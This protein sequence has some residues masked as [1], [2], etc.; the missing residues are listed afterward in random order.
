[1]SDTPFGFSNPDDDP[2]RKKDEGSGSGGG[3]PFGF[4][5]PGGGGDNPFG[6]QGFDPAQFGQM[7]SQFGQMLAGMGSAMG[8]GGAGPVNYEIAS[9][10]AR[11]Q[12]GSVTPVSAG[13]ADAVRDASRLAELWLDAATTLPAG[14]TKTVA[15]TPVEWLENTLDTWKRLCDPIAEQVNG[16]MLQGLP[17]EARAM[18]GPMMGMFSQMGGVAFGSQL[19]QALGQLS[20]EVMTSTDIGLPLGPAGT[21]ALLPAAIEE[22]GEGLEQP[23]QEI[24][25]FIAAR[26]AA[27]QRLYSH[28]PWLRQRLLA[29]VEEYARGIRMDMSSIEDLA[30]GLDPSALSD[31][32]KIEEIL[33]QG[34]FEPQT[35]PEQLAALERLETMLALV[36]GWVETVVI[37]ALGDRLPGVAALSETLRRRRATGGPAEQTF[38]T[39]VGL[40]LRPRKLREAAALWRRLTTDAGADA[41]DK[42]WEHPDL[43]PD[44]SDLDNP[45]AFVDRVIGGG[46][47]AFEDP[48]AQLR[49]TME[50]ERAEKDQDGGDD[51]ADRE[52]DDDSGKNS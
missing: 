11:Q 31:P 5:L 9:K 7:L 50:R 21:A 24:L 26:E 15:W 2:D 27:H 18:A 13:T 46:T 42:V 3:S 35:T 28:V 44:S 16:M 45:A 22:F 17:E 1:M 48:I 52:P 49:E 12:I 32:S 6:A 33:K 38:A 10:L 19:G 4:G 43:L 14:A 36:E 51:T 20:K 37:D 39:L 34:A 8:T 25:V 23:A 47:S 30:Q 41:R 29:I 40:E